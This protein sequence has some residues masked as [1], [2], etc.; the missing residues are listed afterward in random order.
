M[1]DSYNDEF[2]GCRDDTDV[3]A[4]G[5]RKGDKWYCRE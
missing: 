5:A 1:N 3:N 2:N 4:D